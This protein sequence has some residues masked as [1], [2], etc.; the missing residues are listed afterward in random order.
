MT[1]QRLIAAALAAF[2]AA[3]AVPIA[4]AQL[5]FAGLLNAFD[6]HG[7]D[8]PAALRVLAGVSGFGT[9][10]VAAA[11]VVGSALTILGAAAA[12]MVIIASAC[13]GLL[14]ATVLWIPTAVVLGSAACLLPE[15]GRP[16][17]AAA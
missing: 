5:D 9:V 14:T 13:A 12:R 17:P 15:P 6:I 4:L 8:A 16:A 7:G 3:S 1:T 11:A 2:A 10:A